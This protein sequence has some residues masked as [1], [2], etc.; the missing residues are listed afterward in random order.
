VT[1]IG[2]FTQA[3]DKENPGSNE[4]RLVAV[5]DRLYAVIDGATDKSGQTH[6]GLTGGQVAGRILEDVLRDAA[7]KLG[8]NG[9][10]EI[11]VSTILDGFNRALRRQY[12]VHGIADAIRLEPWR[13]FAAQASIVVRENSHYRFI[14]VGDTGLRI[15]GQEVFFDR[16]PGDAICAQLRAAMYRHLVGIGADSETVEKWARAYT[17]N[18]LKIV[19]PG[20]PRALGDAVLGQLRDKVQAKCRTRAPEIAPADVENVLLEGLKGLHRYRNRPGPLGFPCLDGS[21]VPRDMIVEFRRTADSINCIELFSDGYPG[22]PD[23]TEVEDWEALHAKAERDDP[24]RISVFPETKG[25]APDRFADDR[26]IL[27]VRPD[28]K[29][30]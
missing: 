5:S 8:R 19:L 26:T 2:A 6:D 3:K 21:S 25:S 1:C 22:V 13:G 12:R 24:E 17:V 15:N 23:R 30:N 16:K 14:I 4:D 20:S 28:S 11:P 18:G 10:G 27:I 7:L 9:S 29:G